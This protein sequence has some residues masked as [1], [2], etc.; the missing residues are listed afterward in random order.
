M[1]VVHRAVAEGPDG[2]AWTCVIKR[3]LPE[4]SLNPRFTKML[5]TEARVS[6]LL[7]HPAIV[8]VY[9]LGDV[10]GEYFLTMEYVDGVDLRTL[11]DCCAKAGRPI[12]IGQVC[13]LIA[14]LAAALAYAH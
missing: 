9:E 3:V 7:H 6:A 2:S 14:E 11:V 8:Q 12:P 1:A 10:D 4:L 5:L 13:F